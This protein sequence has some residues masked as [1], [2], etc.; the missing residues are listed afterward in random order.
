MRERW[1]IHADRI[2]PRTGW[3]AAAVGSTTPGSAGRRTAAGTSR[4]TA[5]TT[6]AFAWPEVRL[7][8]ST[9]GHFKGERSLERR[10][11]G[12]EE[13]EAGARRA[14]AEGGA[15]HAQPWCTSAQELVYRYV[16]MALVPR[17]RREPL[18][19]A[20]PAR[21]EAEPHGPP[22]RPGARVR[23]RQ[24]GNVGHLCHTEFCDSQP[25]RCG[26]RGGVECVSAEP[27][28]DV[29]GSSGGWNTAW[30]RSGAS[31]WST[32][33]GP[34]PRFLA[35]VGT[36]PCTGG[37]SRAAGRRRLCRVRAAAGAREPSSSTQDTRSAVL[38]LQQRPV[39]PDD[40]EAGPHEGGPGGHRPGRRRPRG[41]IRAAVPG[42]AGG[43]AGPAEAKAPA[44]TAPCAGGPEAHF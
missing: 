2:R 41:E 16:F 43:T 38:D 25:G 33:S 30:I 11:T 4:R 19:A 31:A 37:L 17:L 3:Y 18:L 13:R 40:P 27:S 7:A 5:A 26:R 32:W 20:P 35:A 42:T 36:G 1:R 15:G 44:A 29:R 21:C 22:I 10:P 6:W 9:A 24:C 28:R 14:G 34:R 12:T 23:E 39:G 8:K